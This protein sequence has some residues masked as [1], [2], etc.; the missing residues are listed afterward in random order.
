MPLLPSVA[1]MFDK[2]RSQYEKMHPTNPNAGDAFDTFHN[3]VKSNEAYVTLFNDAY[4]HGL[5]KKIDYLPRDPKS[6]VSGRSGFSSRSYS[7]NSAQTLNEFKLMKDNTVVKVVDGTFGIGDDLIN[8]ASAGGSDTGTAMFIVA[9]ELGHGFGA[10]LIAPEEVSSV[11][12]MLAYIKSQPAN[13]TSINVQSYVQDFVRVKSRGEGLATIYAYNA[14]VDSQ[15]GPITD[16]MRTTAFGAYGVYLLKLDAGDRFVGGSLIDGITTDSANK[17]IINDANINILATRNFDWQNRHKTLT[18]HNVYYAVIGLSYAAANRSDA[19]LEFDSQVLG[20]QASEGGAT[21]TTEQALN[22]MSSLFWKGTHILKDTSAGGLQYKVIST[23]RGTVSNVTIKQIPASGQQLPTPTEAYMTLSNVDGERAYDTTNLHFVRQASGVLLVKVT[24]QDGEEV[25]LT[26]TEFEKVFHVKAEDVFAVAIGQGTGDG[27][28]LVPV[29]IS[30]QDGAKTIV[31]A[32]RRL[33]LPPGLSIDVIGGIATPVDYLGRAVSYT[34]K[35]G[36][37]VAYSAKDGNVTVVTTLNDDLEPVATNIRLDNNPVGIEFSDFGGVLGQQLGYRLAGGDRLAGI[38]S[39]ATL[40]TLGDNFGDLVDGIVGKQSATSATRDAFATVSEEFLGNLKS[41][42]VGAVSSFLTAELVGLIGLE[43]FE[44]GLANTAAGA[45]IGQVLTN[46]TRLGETVVGGVA[47]EVY[48][49][50]TGVNLSLVGSAVGSFFGSFLAAKVISFDTVGGQIG[51]AVGSALGTLAMTELFKVGTLLGGPVG[52]AIGAFVGFIVGGL[53][54]SVFGGIP[55]SGADSQWDEAQQKFVVA[56]VYSRKGGSK[57]AARS[58]A[59]AVSETFNSVLAATGG[60]L[61]NPEAVQSG[62]YGMR[63]KDFVYR[64]GSTRDRQAITQRFSGKDAATRLI[65]YGVHQGLTDPDFQIAGGDVY[66]KRALY[67][68]FDLGGIDALDF[69]TNILLGNI[70]SAQSY[71]T[72]LQNS[73][74]INA[75]VSAEPD[76]VFTTETLI[77]LARADELGLTRRHRSD[78]FGGFAFLMD[79]AQTNAA[80]VEFGFDYDPASGQVSR[81]IGIGDYT[82][83][84]AIDIAGQTTIEGTAGID[85]IDLRTGTLASQAGYTVNGLL[86]DEIAVSGVDFTAATSTVSLTATSLRINAPVTIKANSANSGREA[87]DVTLSGAPGVLATIMGPPATVTIVANSDPAYLMVGRSYVGEGDGYAQFRVSLSKAVSSAVTFSLTLSEQGASGGAVDYGSATGPSVEVW[88]GSTWTAATSATIAAGGTSL[89]LRVAIKTDNGTDAQ[90]KATNV[91]GNERFALTATVT[92]GTSLLANGATPV[93]GIG[94]ILDATFRDPAKPVT[95]LDDIIVHEPA[96]GTQTIN[97]VGTRATGSASAVTL[98]YQTSDRRALDIDIAATIDGGDGADIIYASD[99]GD[100]IFGGAGNDTLYGGRL[101]DWLLG[102]DGN[103]ILTASSVGSTSLGGDGNYLNGGA[104]SD[105]LYGREGSDWLEGGDGNDTLTGAA[106]DDILAGGAGD[107]DSLKGGTGSD[108]YL[109]RRGDGSDLAEEDATGAPVDTGAGDAM[110]QRAAAIQAWKLNPTTAGALRPDWVGSAAGVQAE[111]VAGGEDAIIFG[112]GINIGDIKLQRSGTSTTPGNDLIVIVMTTVGTTE[113]D[114]GTRLTIKDWFSNPFKRVEWLKFADGNEMRIGDLTSFVIGGAGN[115]ILIG[116]NGND[117]V[118]GGAGDDKLLLL[119]GDDVGNGALGDD[120]VS[121]G[122]GRDML[123]GGL[124]G[125]TLMGDAGADALTGD[126]GTDDLYGGGDRDILAGGRGDGDWVVGGTG[127]DTFKYSRG[128]GRDLYFDEYAN[129]WDVVWTQAGGWNAAAGYA[130]NASTGEVTGPGGAVIRKNFGTVAEPDFQWV[131]RFSYDSTTSTY[132]RFVPPANAT[133][134]TANAGID[135]IELSPDINLQDVILRRPVGTNDLVLAIS[136]E[137]EELGDTSLAKDSITIRDWYVSPGQ[138]E[139]IAFYQTGILNIASTKL[140]AGSDLAD[141]TASAPLVGTLAADW[142]TGAA[143]DDVIAG[144]SGNDILAGNSGFDTLKG[145]VGDDVLYGGNGDDIL[146]GGVGKDVLIGGSGQD[147]ASYASAAAAVKVQLT[148]ANMNAGDADGDEYHAIEDLIGGSGADVLGGDGGQNELT[149]GLGNDTL[150][151]N[152]GDDVYVWNIGHGA[153][154]IRDISFVME[155][156]VTTAGVLAAGY[157]VS[158]VDTGTI[159][160]T[161]GNHYWQLKIQAPDGTFIYDSSSYSYAA[162]A[163]PAVPVPSAYIQGGWLGGFARTNGQQVTR[164][165]YDSDVNAGNDELEFGPDISLTD[166]TFTRVNNDLVIRYGSTSASQ[167][168][169]KYHYLAN[170]AVETLK[171]NDGLSAS[172]MAVKIATSDAQLG[173]GSTDDIMVG[174]AGLTSVNFG[175]GSGRDV[176]IGTTGDDILHGGSGDDVLE[177]GA[178]ADQIDGYSNNPSTSGPDAG[179]TVRYVRSTAGVTVDLTLTTPQGGVAGS[180]AAGDILVG[181]ENLVGSSFNDALTG[182]ANDNRLLGL[183]G[184]DILSGGAGDDVLSG[185][186]GNDTLYGDAGDDALSGGEDHDTL[187]GGTEDDV[188]DGGDGN[189]KLYGNDG[190][191]DLI[192]GTGLDILSG[193]NGDDLLSGGADADTLVGGGGNDILNGGSGDDNLQD[194]SGNDI[195]AFDR[196][197]GNDTLLDL[198]GTNILTFDESVSYDELWLTR[199]G[200]DLRVSVIGGG[201]TTMVTDFFLATGQT[202]VHA[203]QTT[204]HAIFLD[205]PD[206]LKLV[207]AMTAATTTPVITPATMPSAIG[208]QLA[209]YWHAGGKS[210]PTGPSAPRTATMLEDGTLTIDGDYDVIDHDQNIVSYSLKAGSGPSKGTI[211]SLNT[212]TGA[213]TYTP[214]ADL[215]GQDSFVVIATDADGHAVE[216]PVQVNITPVNDA[217]RIIGLK[218]GALTVLESAPGSLTA[219]GDFLAKFDVI[220]VEGDPITYTLPNDAGGRFYITAAA[221]LRVLDPTLLNREIASSHVVQVKATDSYGASSVK[222]FTVTVGNVNEAPNVAVLTASR[223]VV[224]EYVGATSIANISTLVAQFTTSD[225]DGLPVP[226]L[227]FVTDTTGNPAGRFKIVGTQ[228]QFAIEPNFEALV[229]AGFTVS[230]SDGDGRAEVSLT[231]NIRA[232]DGSLHSD[233]LT[234]FSVKVEDTNE[235]QTAITLA[236]ALASINERDRLATGTARPAI[237]L[238]TLGVTDPDLVGQLTGQHS[239]AVF[240]GSSTVASTRFGVDAANKLVL[241]ANKSLDYETDGAAIT[242]KVRAA[243]KSSAPFLL[244]QNFV[245]AIN[246]VDDVTEGTAAADDIDG[247]QNRDIIRGMAGNDLLSGGSG[248]DV[249]EGGDGNDLLAGD[250]GDDAL[251]GQAGLDQIDGGVGNDTLYGGD[252]RDD[253]DGGIGNDTLNGEGGNDGV[254]AAGDDAWRGF[255]ALG[256]TGGDGTDTLNGG[257]GDDYLDGGLGA[258]QLVGG[259]GFDG[260]TYAAST[261]AVTVSLA[262]GVGTGGSAQGDTLTGIELLQGSAY[263]DTL[264]GSAANDIIY[265]EVGNDIIRGGAGQDYLFGG[266]GNDSIDAEAGNDYLDGGAGDDTLIGGADNDTYH[267]ARNQGNDRIQNYDATGTN[268]DHLSFDNTVLY[269]DIWF[270]RVDNAGAVNAAGNHLRMTILGASGSEGSV[271]IDNWFTIPDRNVPANYFKIDLISDGVE[272][273]VIPINVDALTTLMAGIPLASRPTTRAQMATLRSGNISFSNSMEEHWGRL[274]PPRVS[275]I[276]SISGTEPLDAAT[277]TVSFAVRAWFEDNQGLGVVIP[278]SSI[279]LTI[280]AGNGQILT[281]YVSAVNTGT[282]DANGNRTVTLTLAPNASTHLLPG[283]VLSLQMVAQIRGTSRTASDLNGFTLSIAPTADTGTFTQLASSGG[284]AGTLIPLTIAVTSPDS[285]DGSERREVLI[286]GLPAGYSLVNAAGAP[287][288]ILEGG[289]TWRLTQAQLVGL[290]MSAPTGFGNAPL[291]VAVQTIDGSSVRTSAWSPLTVTV[292]GKPTNITLAGSVA[293]NAAYGTLV[294]TLTGSDPDTAEGAPAPSIFQLLNDAGGRYRLDPANTSRLLVN[295]GGTTPFDYEAANRDSLHTITVRVTDNS[296]LTFDKQIVVPMTNVNEAPLPPSGGTEIVKYV[297]ENAV[298]TNGVVASL[299]LTDPDGTTPTLQIVGGVNA[300]WFTIAGN[301]VK[302]TGVSSFN[303]ETYAADPNVQKYDW[304]GDG[305]L[306]ARVAYVDVRANDGVLNSSPTR[307]AV[308]ISDLNEQPYI[309]SVLSSTTYSEVLN[310]DASLSNKIVATFSI[311]DPDTP[312]PNLVITNNP[313]GWFQIIDGDQLAFAPTANFTAG[314]LRANKGQF[315]IGSDYIYDADG[316][317]LKEIKLATVTLKATDAAGLQSAAYSYNVFIEDKNEAPVWNAIPTLIVQE[318]RTSGYHIWSLAALDPDGP[319]SELRYSFVGG[320]TFYDA[321]LGATMSASADGRFMI[322]AS[323]GNLFVGPSGAFNFES[324]PNNFNYQVNVQDKASGAHSITRTSNVS[325]NIADLNEAHSLVGA[326]GSRAEFGEAPP[327][328]PIFNLADNSTGTRMLVDPENRDMSWSFAD[329]SYESGIWAISTDGK[330]SLKEGSVDYE[331]LTAQQRATTLSIKA[332]DGQFVATG[333][334]AAT[335]TNV[336]EAPT[337]SGTYAGEAGDTDSG[338][339]IYQQPSVWWVTANRN[340]GPLVIVYP[341]DPEGESTTY[342]YSLSTPETRDENVVYGGSSEADGEAPILSV[343]ASGAYGIISFQSAGD[344]EWEGAYE[345]DGVRRTA[346][347]YYD[348]DLSIRDTSGMT[349]VHPF[350]IVFLR[351][352]SSVPP[353]V[354]D[355]DGDGVELVAYDSSTI[356][357]DMDRDG[358]ADRTGWAEADDGFLALDRNHNGTID[359]IAE[360]SFVGDV[361]GALSDGEGLRAFDTNENGFLDAGD[362]RF[363]EFLVW[364]DANQ[365]GVSEASEL[366]ALSAHSITA[367]NLTLTATGEDVDSP[368]NVTFATLEVQHSDGTTSAGADVIFTFDPSDFSTE[369]AAPI[370][371]DFDGDGSGLTALGGSQTLFDMNKDGIADQTGWIKPGDALLA[372]DRNG[373]GTIDDIGEISFVGDKAGA[374][375]DLEGLAG[376]DA[377]GDGLLDGSDERFVEFKLWFDRDANGKTDAGELLSLAEARIDAIT[378]QGVATGQA[379]VPG[380]NIIYNTSSY[381]LANGETGHLL[382]AGFAFKALSALPEIALQQSSWDRNAKN[383]SI[384]STAGTLHVTARDAKGVIDAGAGLV[385]PASIM[386]FANRSVG[387]LSTII[388]DLDGDGLEARRASKTNAAF[389]MDGDGTADNTGWAGKDDAMLVIDH[390]ADA[391]ITHPS[392][393]SFLSEKTDAKN[394][395]EGLAILDNSKDG[396]ITAGDAR[397][398]ELKLWADSNENGVTDMGELKSLAD[399]GIKEISLSSTSINGPTKLG[400]NLPLSTATFTRDNGVTATIGNVALAFSPSSTMDMPPDQSSSGMQTSV[401]AKAA[402]HSAAQLLQAMSSFG[403]VRS[404]SDLQSAVSH[405]QNSGD[406]FAANAA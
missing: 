148:A 172:L 234:A 300:Q 188:L 64:P 347:R 87:F 169:I 244:D 283:G 275:D 204:T 203:I 51:S 187:S 94:T 182:D 78:W 39:S 371:F 331:A 225:P 129:Y 280:S 142:I 366:A 174:A 359:D 157:V 164:Q 212:T 220:D 376:F 374:K 223:G 200:N 140:I 37:I 45:V 309:T 44:G 380:Q 221:N 261:A 230:D 34:Y 135:T 96:S 26:A 9:H 141:G 108:Q 199:V 214:F 387:M 88:N 392:E 334:F 97:V 156:A 22:Q 360:I 318:D 186:R 335:I 161:S 65:G 236:G 80:N 91:E 304:N 355:L 338:R 297:D 239:F 333:T 227:M 75:L 368:D 168:T 259:L 198:S 196:M 290:K 193:S 102:G 295:N 139:N 306:D 251:S 189:D 3:L 319:S 178:G 47:G 195:Y 235:Q 260:A 176:L 207:T 362:E 93:V 349:G 30:D 122:T 313:N 395:W 361:E 358:V 209:T 332:F 127:D 383:Y 109:V 404:D 27:P 15:T 328:T 246:N 48:K 285:A 86:Q 194:P 136:D 323:D 62:N 253:L 303:Y 289:T 111:K 224:S 57:D 390:N 216:L 117:F 299:T 18:S 357:F 110:T 351:R 228:V 252:D 144:G 165:R 181:V 180:D 84:D 103:D 7:G 229:N 113:S 183:L 171:L 175:G 320:S 237:I 70:S 384:V 184:V 33:L 206:A 211:S 271:T 202:R 31:V 277:Q 346:T 302:F 11:N 350:Q 264:T 177:G 401:M 286:K 99:L 50:F 121:G 143:G 72:Y 52:A 336:N 291:Q 190:N 402:E 248:N 257:D 41:A 321:G 54:G 98:N 126:G 301:Q 315:G 60:T 208:S 95:W 125:D 273:A 151:G 71:A 150:I 14:W 158:W 292:N 263:G 344:G 365:N 270:D 274:S 353:I 137:D 312:E 222:N 160:A 192:G 382:D 69:D 83:G 391:L 397:F 21:Y 147:A 250:D 197:S 266:L 163:S 170:H 17:I 101:D 1:G 12:T 131:G 398:S 68:T 28:I 43:G 267:V 92:A 255:T 119:G 247:Q 49:P 278:A 185:D 201:T 281:D 386:T 19:V 226:G 405:H 352:N 120:Q 381:L 53:I 56:N 370:V 215:N 317:G 16:S 66:V 287:V 210:A 354:L 243:D 115:D 85:I 74:V 145:E 378:L 400:S 6:N 132:K 13:V 298:I 124:G 218:T 219:N 329:G 166:L 249:I 262:T 205:H 279:D 326:S 118:Y 2:A 341:T 46:L 340:E 77:T 316:D 330:L 233:L 238:G 112:A 105:T 25:T 254:R 167:V 363:A 55:R 240:E 375:T 5:L 79:E 29:S 282:P 133:T 256:L 38:V 379:Q 130:H 73:A 269:T 388:L 348:F 90:G 403:A 107:N 23:K 310:G 24:D 20:L 106:G 82:L 152:S 138:I 35:N 159:D 296:G 128:D 42:G 305:R 155:E 322:K 179:D 104:G 325:L 389:D 284:H 217:P 116:T 293:E 272:R 81:L 399:A 396:K 231:G 242:I 276:V 311:G 342:S 173:G 307:V 40:K 294:G 162:G 367:I 36:I 59:S 213:L 369:I 153:D 191:D 394:A 149:G 32:Q 268:F 67:A 154:F 343:N 10:A 258:D 406:W 265:G 385:S 345:L 339:M 76:S 288:G 241:L 364:N 134:I 373:N 8:F 114:S 337:I 377:N 308:L 63:K 327:L 146:D 4:T 89:S 58:V 232:T 61:L 393:L 356:D 314:W 324:G 245:F 100:N 123:I 372:L